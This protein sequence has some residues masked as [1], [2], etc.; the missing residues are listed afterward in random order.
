V[1]MPLKCEK[2]GKIVFEGICICEECIKL[3]KEMKQ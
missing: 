1:K 3:E 2:C